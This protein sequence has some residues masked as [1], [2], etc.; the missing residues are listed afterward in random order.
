MRRKTIGDGISSDTTLSVESRARHNNKLNNRGRSPTKG[1]SK[2]RGKS[3]AKGPENHR[4]KNIQLDFCK[5]CAYENKKR[6]SFQRDG[7]KRKTE[8]LELV[9][10]DVCRSTIVKSLEE[11]QRVLLIVV[12]KKNGKSSGNHLLQHHQ[13]EQAAEWKY[14]GNLQYSNVLLLSRHYEKLA[15]DC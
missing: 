15:G 10:M 1:R 11:V 3:K 2:S 4:I 14:L 8:P 9:H 13:K 12:L 6:V 5:G 7:K